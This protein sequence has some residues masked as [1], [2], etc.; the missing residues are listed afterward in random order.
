MAWSRLVLRAPSGRAWPSGS[1][2]ALGGHQFTRIQLGTNDAMTGD[3]LLQIVLT[4]VMTS[5][6]VAR[7]WLAYLSPGFGRRYRKSKGP[8]MPNFNRRYLLPCY[9]KDALATIGFAVCFPAVFLLGPTHSAGLPILGLG[10]L[11][12]VSSVLLSDW[13]DKRA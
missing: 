3:Y 5:G 12:L 2:L 4:L 11:P 8:W 9:V 1:R 10:L 13:I 6:F 7:K